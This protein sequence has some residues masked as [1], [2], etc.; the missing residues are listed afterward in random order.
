V[1]SRRVPK[2]IFAGSA[3]VLLLLVG[4]CASN[5]K[6]G[7]GTTTTTSPS[8]STSSTTPSTTTSSI[9]VTGP[10]LA[11]IA[12]SQTVTVGGKKVA[13]PTDSGRPIPATGIGDGQ[14]IIISVGGFLPPRLYASPSVPVVWTNLTDQPQQVVFDHLA[15]R[16]PVIAPGGTFS[17]TSQDSESISYH[18]VSG[19]H[20]VLVLNPPGV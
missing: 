3:L 13:V 18:S 17:W 14:Q 15:V 9:P 5:T 10:S 11:T 19:M 1:T 8:T 4:G 2:S 20:A 16:S 7:S 12:A 6:A